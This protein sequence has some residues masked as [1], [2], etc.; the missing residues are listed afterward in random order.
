MV[1][2]PVDVVTGAN[3]DGQ[4][5]FV[6]SGPLPLP[7]SRWYD[8]RRNWLPGGLGWGHTH[9]Y[10]RR[11]VFDL[12]GSR[13]FGPTGG[14]VALP[15][16][17][18]D[19]DSFASN[20][21]SLLRVNSRTYILSQTGHPL[22][23]FEV[24]DGRQFARLTA[25]GQGIPRVEFRYDK[26]G[27][28]HSILDSK[29][30]PIQVEHDAAGRVS[31]LSL[32]GPGGKP[33]RLVEYQYDGGGNLA[34]VTDPYNNTVRYQFDP[35]HRQ[36]RRTD[37][38]GYS[39]RFAYD[40]LGRCVLAG[41]EDGTDEV[42][43]QY[44]PEH[45]AT[46]VTHIDGGEWL[47]LYD[48]SGVV[49]KI[50]EPNGAVRQF[51]KDER[52]RVAEEVDPAGRVTRRVFDATG[53]LL[54]TTDPL[55]FFRAKDDTDSGPPEH[56]V[57]ANP[58]EWDL[59]DLPLWSEAEMPDASDLARAGLDPA[60]VVHVRTRTPGI[61]AE[62]KVEYDDFGIRFRDTFPDG[63]TRRWVYDS[64]RNVTRYTD[65]EGAA[66]TVE[67]TSWNL[68]AR[69]TDPIGGRVQ[70][71]YSPA[72]YTT[73]VTDP[74]GT[75]SEYGY[76]LQDRLVE[77][78]R[79]GMLREK[80][81]YDPA[82]KLIGK[83]DA[84]GTELLQIEVGH[85]GL[86]SV[87]RLAS[88][89]VH[90]FT[91]TPQGRFLTAKTNQ[92]TVGF[93]YDEFGR[94]TKDQR[95]GLGV[96]HLSD[97]AG[98]AETV[99]LG[100]FS[101]RYE[102]AADD[103]LVVI[104]PTGDRH[105]VR[106]P[107]TGLVERTLAN[108]SKEVSQYGERGRCLVRAKT[109]AGGSGAWVRTYRYSPEGDLLAGE[110]TVRGATRYRYDATHR[111]VGL[112]RLNG[113]DEPIDLDGAGNILRMPGLEGVSLRDG[114]RLLSANGETFEYD[115]RN[116]I[117]SRTGPAGTTRYHYDSRD[118]LIRVE[119][120]GQPD[121]TAGYDPLGRRAWK[122]RGNGH[123]VEFFWDTDRLA[124]ERDETGRVRVYVYADP[125]AMVPLMFVDYSSLTAEPAS[126][127]RYYVFTDQ[128]GTPLL[129]E[130]QAGRTVWA[131][132]FDPHGRAMVEPGATIEITLRFPG[133]FFDPETGLHYNRFRYYDPVLGRYLQSD[134][135]GIA[136]GL[137]VYGYCEGNPLTR[138][139]VRGLR[140][141]ATPSC[142][143]AAGTGDGTGEDPDGTEKPKKYPNLDPHDAENTPAPGRALRVGGE[144]WSVV[145]GGVGRERLAGERRIPLR[146]PRRGHHGAT[147]RPQREYPHGPGRRRP[148]GLCRPGALQS[149]R[150]A[151]VG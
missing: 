12:D 104:D 5:D 52:G 65:R 139:D 26:N 49:T 148:G 84:A 128:I 51:V 142:G 68:P 47:Y 78:R 124:A 79:H 9:E 81:Q 24:A 35:E 138:V 57:A 149:W 118:M 146:H 129:V 66:T 70:L 75:L 50:I 16:L 117:S 116:H 21:Y 131:A 32:P 56:R 58:S 73:A 98:V 102:W 54:G 45:N 143:T 105:T 37:R 103:E 122:A 132:Q 19:G 38:R 125:F 145:Y 53:A 63:T 59:G 44:A 100:R 106:F 82:G 13:Y 91:Y 77:V 135:I 6:L 10:E 43:L 8:T 151:E 20:G 89:D 22:A 62:S 126:G 23:T 7:W 134:P 133:H 34:R 33:K 93:E 144:E 74:G 95:D 96:E 97:Q 140:Q 46:L 72:R 119:R 18:R 130:D 107:A 36:V 76:D 141:S 30:R 39:F 109:R 1:G 111:L 42:R 101:V 92:C 3:L 64:N 25:L 87:R 48:A 94:R 137:N 99:L 41:G 123:K 83:W 11:L 120:P 40:D 60:A 27:Q 2:D 71:K 15:P 85:N 147:V 90:T 150:I 67:Y 108:G 29:R 31:R 61:A 114:N 115:H 112:K 80:Y 28:L 14:P 88:G 69:M 55:G 113:T 121:W 110:D 86:P 136:G 127:V 4:T 17:D